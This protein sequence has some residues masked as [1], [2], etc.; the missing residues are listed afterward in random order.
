MEWI[1][2]ITVD[3]LVFYTEGCLCMITYRLK[4]TATMLND[5]PLWVDFNKLYRH[6]ALSRPYRDDLVRRNLHI[7]GVLACRID[8]SV[9]HYVLSTLNLLQV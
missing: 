6:K 3:C 9:Q 2:K 5:L 8:L 7:M 1:F 4:N